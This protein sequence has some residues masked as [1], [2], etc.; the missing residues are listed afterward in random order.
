V[1][2]PSKLNA[3]MLSRHKIWMSCKLAQWNQENQA[4]LLRL[5]TC[6]W[7]LC[8]YDLM[9]RSL[10]QDYYV[11]LSP[12]LRALLREA[13][14]KSPILVMPKIFSHALAFC[15]SQSLWWKQNA[16]HGRGIIAHYNI[17]P[18]TSYKNCKRSFQ[19]Q[20]GC[21]IVHTTLGIKQSQ[22]FTSHDKCPV[23]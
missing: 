18:D 22:T 20:I 1:T 12:S 8:L 2:S 3:L 13:N 17:P 14:C 19:C 21:D 11:S 7:H 6:Q 15:T 4:N 5:H 9:L 10:P 16:S 23:V